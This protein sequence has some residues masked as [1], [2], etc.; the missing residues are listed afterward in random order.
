M[1]TKN[2]TVLFMADSTNLEELM[3]KNEQTLT[4]CVGDLL[5]DGLEALGKF[6]ILA[7]LP[8]LESDQIEEA[9]REEGHLVRI[10]IEHI[11]WFD[12]PDMRKRMGWSEHQQ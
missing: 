8:D 1:T 12:D 5:R 7:K 4:E 10:T 2:R 6:G 9:R 11:D 3:K